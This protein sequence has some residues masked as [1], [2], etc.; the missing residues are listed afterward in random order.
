MLCFYRCREIN[1][2]LQFLLGVNETTFIDEGISLEYRSRGTSYW[3]PIRYYAPSLHQSIDSNVKLSEDQLFVDTFLYSRVLPVR[4][5]MKL[6]EP[7]FYQDF[8]SANSS[9]LVIRWLQRYSS[10]YPRKDAAPWLIDNVTLT[11]W[12]GQCRQ[13]LLTEDFEN[14]TLSR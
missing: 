4:T 5:V 12:D 3:Q 2:D 8:I 11:Y 1:F 13:M 7:G 6:S 14:F 9:N 10:V